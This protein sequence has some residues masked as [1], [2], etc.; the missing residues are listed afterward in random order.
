MTDF[1]HFK[2]T[3]LYKDNL[4]ITATSG[5]LM[6]SENTKVRQVTLSSDVN[7][8]WK[9]VTPLKAEGPFPVAMIEFAPVMWMMSEM[10]E[11]IRD[12]SEES[13]NR[14]IIKLYESFIAQNGL[15]DD[16]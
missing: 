3:S 2:K 13:A 9:V 11:I 10:A 6:S 4:Q 5:A 12:I 14:P 16:L 8:N 1:P 15:G 7:Y